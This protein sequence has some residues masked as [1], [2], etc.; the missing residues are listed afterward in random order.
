MSAKKQWESA[1]S[2]TSSVSESRC[3]IWDKPPD[4]DTVTKTGAVLVRIAESHVPVVPKYAHVS[5]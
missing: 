2:V 5:T 1:G 3:A 4:S